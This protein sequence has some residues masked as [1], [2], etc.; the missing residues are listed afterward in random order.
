MAQTV[1]AL[2]VNSA[3]N[4]TLEVAQKRDIDS[5]L[6]GFTGLRAISYVSSAHLRLEFPEKRGFESVGTGG[7]SHP[8]IRS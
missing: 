4:H 2:D 5:L 8:Q 1:L 6:E 3:L 7:S